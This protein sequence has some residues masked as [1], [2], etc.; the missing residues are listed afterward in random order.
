MLV[1]CMQQDHVLWMVIATQMS[2]VQMDTVNQDHVPGQ[3]SVFLEL[4]VLATH[5]VVNIMTIFSNNLS[6]LGSFSF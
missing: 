2:D 6:Y 3:D 5:V 1:Y 4:S